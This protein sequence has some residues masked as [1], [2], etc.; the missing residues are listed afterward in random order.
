MEQEQKNIS[1]K[2]KGVRT[3]RKNTIIGLAIAT[4][5]LGA[6]TVGL[7]I[8][9]GV[10]MSQATNYSIKLENIYKKNYYELVDNVNSADMKISKV[11]AS[12][13]SAY[14][15]KVLTE[16]SQTAKEMQTNVASLPIN[17]DNIYQSVRFINQMSGYTQVLEEKIAEGGALSDADKASLSNMHEA[18]TEMK[19]QINEISTEI[20]KGYSITEASAKVSGG[21]DSFSAKYVNLKASDADFPTMIYDGPFSDSVVNQEV[22]GLSGAVVSKEDVFRKI[23]KLFKNIT[24]LK[25]EGETKGKFNTYNFSMQTTDDQELFVQVTKI[26]GHVLNVNGNIES[27][28]KKIGYDEAKKIALDFA[29][30]NGVEDA[31]VV[32]D[33]QLDNQTYFNITPKVDGIILYPDLVKVKIDMEKGVVAGYDAVSYFTNHTNRSLPKAAISIENASVGVD[34]SF[35]IVSQRLVLAPL[36]YAQEVLCYEFE[37][38]RNGATY[39]IYVNAATGV[40]ENVLK[41]VETNDGSK[42]M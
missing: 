9:Y 31:T 28:G 38:Q 25:F 2:D 8:A 7:G 36:D 13:N 29:E 23:D 39:Y 16:L 26:G 21:K 4:G 19:R 35:E 18:L 17:N 1:N 15:G 42:L 12:N 3:K 37:C 6:T 11:L 40:E 14:Q 30:E 27:E 33:E 41:V 5:I 34:E 32:W 22:K 10:S 24:N 20:G